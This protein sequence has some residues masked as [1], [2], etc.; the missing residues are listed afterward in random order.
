MEKIEYDYV[1]ERIANRR[2]D[3]RVNPYHRTIAGSRCAVEEAKPGSRGIFLL[4]VFNLE[5]PGY[6]RWYY[7]S[8]IKGVVDT[9]SGLVIETM[10]SS[11]VL[12]RVVP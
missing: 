11:Y 8:L 5:D 9:G 7:T 3:G 6:R 10:N 2:E 12:R 4:E 1:I